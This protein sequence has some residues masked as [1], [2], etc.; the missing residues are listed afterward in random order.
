MHIADVS[1]GVLGANGIVGG[2]IPIAVGAAKGF[3]IKGTDQIAAC[4]FGDG[5]SNN[6]VF[7]ESLNL[8]AI[9]NLPVL[10]ILEN[11]HYAVS[12]RIA[13]TSRSADLADRA[14]GYG[15][16]AET[17]NGNE[18]DLVYRTAERGADL[19][20][21]GEGPFLVECKTYRHGGHHGKDP[22][23][24]MP[25]EEMNF[26]KSENDPVV[27]WRARLILSELA[28]QEELDAIEREVEARL[29]QAVEFAKNSPHPSAEEFIVEVGASTCHV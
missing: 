7:A 14:R 27:N 16:P 22:G 18:V 10:F 26:W 1:S 29:D 15:V 2:G 9:W 5:A 3:K 13:D 19:C 4:F 25:E 11:N 6:G 21:R 12:T 17:I 23:R 28:S 20:R 24:Y 8:A